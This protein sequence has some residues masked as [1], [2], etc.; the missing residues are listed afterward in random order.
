MHQFYFCIRFLRFN[1][2]HDCY[3]GMMPTVG[4]RLQM[5][6]FI[7]SITPNFGRI[8]F[9]TSWGWHPRNGAKRMGE[10]QI[11]HHQDDQ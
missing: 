10:A 5:K 6:Y 1:N 4:Y 11:N 8:F 7:T 9:L 3:F 2:V